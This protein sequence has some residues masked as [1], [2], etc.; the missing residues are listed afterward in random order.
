M[1]SKDQG[2]D[3]GQTH[4][5]K[6][7]VDSIRRQTLQSLRRLLLLVVEAA[8]EAEVVGDEL[9]LLITPHTAND[10]QTLPLRQL[11]HH[12]THRTRRGADK[13]RLALLRLSDFVE[14]R[15]GRQA[16]HAERADEHGGV[17]FVR[18]V[19]DFRALELLLAD[20]SVL[21]GGSEGF[22]DVAGLEVGVVALEDGHDGGVGH[23][24]AEFKG[25]GVA[26]DFRVSHAASL[27]G[28][29]GDIVDFGGDAA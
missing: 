21:P 17:E 28:V 10:L 20:R 15:I 5:F 6:V 23:G 12:R 16:G 18:V 19:E 26:L 3:C 29:E 1:V 24:L 25:R 14:G 8:I 27:V 7:N 11:A 13:N 9:Q 4:V 2:K 22:D